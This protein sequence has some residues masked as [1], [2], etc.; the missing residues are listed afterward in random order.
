MGKL[1]VIHCN[2]KSWCPERGPSNPINSN[3]KKMNCAAIRNIIRFDFDWQLK[4][5]CAPKTTENPQSNVC[6]QFDLITQ[7]CVCSMPNSGSY[8]EQIEV[9]SICLLITDERAIWAP[10]SPDFFCQALNWFGAF[11]HKDNTQEYYILV[12]TIYNKSFSDLESLM[13]ITK[14]N[15]FVSFSFAHNVDLNF[16]DFNSQLQL[17]DCMISIC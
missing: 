6:L 7:L 17:M 10:L 11:S 14:I 2:P 12:A 1:C 13:T 5:Y 15:K 8:V 3:N 9:K 16:F 4:K